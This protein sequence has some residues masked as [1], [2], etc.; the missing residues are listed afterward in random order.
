MVALVLYV[1]KFIMVSNVTTEP[2]SI[3]I[4]YTPPSLEYISIREIAKRWPQLS[5]Q[6]YFAN[7]KSTQEIEA[8]V[9]RLVLTFLFDIGMK[10]S[11]VL[12]IFRDGVS[13][14]SR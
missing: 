5:Y 1:Y 11:V 2:V 10:C 13:C 7:P 14:P 4:P 3:S 12:Y 6:V 9:S 8:N